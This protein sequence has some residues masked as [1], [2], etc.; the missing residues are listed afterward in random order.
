MNVEKTVP[1]VAPATDVSPL[2]NA[3]HEA[4]PPPSAVPPAGDAR[5]SVSGLIRAS[6]ADLIVAC[7]GILNGMAGNA[8]YPAPVP[9]LADINTTYHGFI[10]AVD[11]AKDSRRM[12]VVRNQQRAALC[13][14]LRDLSHYVQ[15]ACNGDRATLLGSGFS[16]WR[17]RR[18]VGVLPSPGNLRLVQ[19]RVSGQL[20]ARCEKLAGAR[21]YEWRYANAATPT[22]WIALEPTFGATTRIEGLVRGAEYLVQTRARGTAGASDWSDAAMLMVV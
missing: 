22:V 17:N 12:I 4:L 13:G 8:A 3:I 18:R 6:D 19:G 20:V 16:A 1:S 7:Q 14:L 9:K 15:V 11:A 21:S 5:V 10:A 2:A